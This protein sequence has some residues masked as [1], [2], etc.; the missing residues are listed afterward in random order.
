MISSYKNVFVEMRA[1]KILRLAGA[2]IE[3][4]EYEPGLGGGGSCRQDLLED[5]EKELLRRQKEII[6]WDRD[7]DQAG[8]QQ[9][10]MRMLRTH[11]FDL[12]ASGRYHLGPGKLDPHGPAG[13]LR[14]VHQRAIEWE[15]DRGLCTS[16][17]RETEARALYQA[18]T[19]K[20]LTQE[21]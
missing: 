1:K 6:R 17:E 13:C 14:R 5:I 12:L 9:I 15:L 18:L 4:C 7:M 20:Q 10:A 19:G 11:S 8:Y 16:Q 2:F 3:Q 21:A